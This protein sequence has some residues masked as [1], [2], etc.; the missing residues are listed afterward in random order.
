MSLFVRKEWLFRLTS[1]VEST[2]LE[3]LV[4]VWGD[5]EAKLCGQRDF[6]SLCGEKLVVVGRRGLIKG[7]EEAPL[8]VDASD[9]SGSISVALF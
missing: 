7:C 2:R 3:V 6:G 5:V 9:Q 4:G 1:S 8:R